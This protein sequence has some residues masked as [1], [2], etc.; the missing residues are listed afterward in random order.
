MYLEIVSGFMIMAIPLGL[1]LAAAWL[2]MPILILSMAKRLTESRTAIEE[3]T[4]RI[5]SLEEQVAR[6]GRLQ[7]PSVN[8]DTHSE[9]GSGGI[10]GTA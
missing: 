6:A 4:S 2:S 9:T 1:L 8:Q 7:P 5:T 10:D 3:L